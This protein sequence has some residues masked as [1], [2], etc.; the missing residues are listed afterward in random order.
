[1]DHELLTVTEASAAAGAAVA[2]E[3]FRTGVPVERKA[4][5]TDVVTAADR[6][7]QATVV[8]RI[9]DSFPDDPVCGEEEGTG[10][11]VPESGRAWVVDPIDGTNNYV[12][13]NR[14]WATSVACVI[15]GEPVAAANLL[16]AMDERYVGSADGVYRNGSR[17]S[18]SDRTDPETF[19]VSPIIWWDL[20]RREEYAAATE[21]IVGRFGDL[22]RIGCAQAALSLVAAGALEGVL[23]NRL[24]APWDTV[25][26]VAMVEWAGGRVT[27]AAGEPWTHRSRGLVVS[28][29]PCHELLVD[30][31]RE[32]DAAA[33]R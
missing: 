33:E 3:A 24:T 31:T 27:D 17:V 16:P 4:G 9:H 28:N 14:R 30:A 12:R 8:D 18:V 21:A 7:A 25:A 10:E 23:T 13:G 19:Q 20:G 26:G 11:T 6:A 1:M 2:L 32:I 15:D 5:K 29:G 22:R